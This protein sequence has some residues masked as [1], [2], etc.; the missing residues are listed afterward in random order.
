MRVEKA[1][2]GDIVVEMTAGSDPWAASYALQYGEL[3]E[4]LE[5]TK[6]RGALVD[7]LKEY[8]ASPKRR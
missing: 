7:R 1:P 8:L 6:A 5:P 2:G 4:I 3:V